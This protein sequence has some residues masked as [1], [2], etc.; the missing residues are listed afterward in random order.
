MMLLA[1]CWLRL[2]W[3][4]T[5]GVADLGLLLDDDVIVVVG[6]HEMVIVVLSC[7]DGIGSGAYGSFFLDATS[8][9]WYIRWFMVW[10]WLMIDSGDVG[11]LSTWVTVQCSSSIIF[12][13]IE[14]IKYISSWF[15]F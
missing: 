13:T 11:S 12:R 10:R 6:L 15:Y 1:D 9:G 14:F 7:I 5:E 2:N 4:V 8:T 3:I